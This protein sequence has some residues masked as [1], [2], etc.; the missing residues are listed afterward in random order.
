[1]ATAGEDAVAGAHSRQLSARVEQSELGPTSTGSSPE[2]SSAVRPFA[3]PAQFELLEALRSRHP[4]LGLT[5]EGALRAFAD[6]QNP[7]SLPQCA[8][9]LRELFDA[10]PLA[11]RAERKKP[12]DL[13]GKVVEIA[14][15]WKHAVPK[16]STLT[17]GRW[18]GDIDG[19][20]RKLLEQF[21]G[22]FSWFEVEHPR[23]TADRDMAL[24]RFDPAGRLLPDHLRKLRGDQL[25]DLQRYMNQVAHHKRLGVTR[26]EFAGKIAETEAM[27][28]TL[29]KPTPYADRKVMDDL[30]K[31]GE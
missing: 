8:H 23:H 5:Y 13:K 9:S 3:D 19:H 16:T 30:L 6:E 27:V 2:L 15:A 4:L 31:G 1:V 25:G 24:D 18:A 12:A 29:V 14:E 10:L 7:E 11:V 26:I 21:A 28:R 22:F 17:G 20:L